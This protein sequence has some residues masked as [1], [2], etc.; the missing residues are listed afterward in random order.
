MRVGLHSRDVEDGLRADGR[1]TIHPG[2]LSDITDH[3]D[4]R[5]QI[6]AAGNVAAKRTRI[7]EELAP[8]SCVDHGYAP[9]S[10]GVAVRDCPS[11][12]NRDA[13]STEIS[14][15]DPGQ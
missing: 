13:E 9:G 14:R 8:K 6:F 3:A 15:R 11:G 5:H 4:N 10:Q 7:M 12:K 1:I 2:A